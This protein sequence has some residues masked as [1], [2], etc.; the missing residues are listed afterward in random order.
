MAV[1]NGTDETTL[2]IAID[3]NLHEVFTYLLLTVML[4]SKFGVNAFH[5]AE[6]VSLEAEEISGTGC[7][8]TAATKGL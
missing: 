3:N 4:R 7:S 1:K 8:H 6:P 2:Y 5:V